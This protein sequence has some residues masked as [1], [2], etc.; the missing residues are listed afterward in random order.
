M[1]NE[2][3][4]QNKSG[5]I[6]A[7]APGNR[8]PNFHNRPPAPFPLALSTKLVGAL[9]LFVVG[10]MFCFVCLPSLKHAYLTCLR[11]PNQRNDSTALQSRNRQRKQA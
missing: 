9:I 8:S 6:Y 7:S 4:V 3:R 11:R 1:L 5:R 10:I 2:A